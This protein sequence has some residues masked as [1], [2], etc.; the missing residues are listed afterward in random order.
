MNNVEEEKEGSSEYDE[1][2]GSK[3]G[4]RLKDTSKAQLCLN[5]SFAVE[6]KNPGPNSKSDGPSQTDRKIRKRMSKVEVDA[7]ESLNI[8]MIEKQI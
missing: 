1:T 4:F 8:S 2:D 5:T 7:S 3:S 6:T